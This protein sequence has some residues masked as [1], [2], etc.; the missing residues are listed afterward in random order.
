MPEQNEANAKKPATASVRYFEPRRVRGYRELGPPLAAAAVLLLWVLPASAQNSDPLEVPV[1]FDEDRARGSVVQDFD[2][3]VPY[4]AVAVWSLSGP[5]RG[6]FAIAADGISRAQL[7]FQAPPD[8]EK[9]ADANR[10]N[11]YEVTVTARVE[12]DQEQWNV[13]VTVNNR[14]AA[15]V[16]SGSRSV[17]FAENSEEVVAAYVAT[18]SAGVAWSVAGADGHLFEIADGALSFTAAPDFE[19]RSRPYQLTVQATIGS[20]TGELDVVVIVTDVDEPLVFIHAPGNGMVNFPETSGTGVATYE[21]FDPEGQ[22]VSW[23][24]SGPDRNLFTIFRGSL[25]FKSRLDFETNKLEYR[26]TVTARNGGGAVSETLLV[27][28]VDVDEDGELSLSSTKPQE[29]TELTVTLSDPDGVPAEEETTWRWYRLGFVRETGGTLIQ[30]ADSAVYTPEDA[31][32]GSFLRAE[33]D[34]SHDKH[35]SATELI[36]TERTIA[37]PDSNSRPNAFESEARNRSVRENSAG[38]VGAPVTTTD[39]DGNTLTYSLSRPDTRL[40]SID[41]DSGQIS[42][43]FKFDHE[44]RSSYRVTVTARDPSKSS[45]TVPVNITVIDVDE[46]LY[47]VT[48][49]SEV[50][51]PENGSGQVGSYDSIDIE[52]RPITWSVYGTD[53]SHFNINNRGVLS[54]NT[55]PDYETKPRYTVTVQATSASLH[56]VQL[57]GVTVTVIDVNEPLSVTGETSVTYVENSRDTVAEYTATDPERETPEWS[58]EGT[59]RAFFEIGSDGRLTFKD[60]PDY[61]A[62]NSRYQVT[63]VASDSKF[64]SKLPV[65]V[66]VTNV[67]EDGAVTLSSS[68][69]LVGTVLRAQVLDPDGGVVATSWKW[70]RWDSGDN[71]WSS[72]PGATSATY[73]PTDDDDGTPLR[74]IVEY[75]DAAGSSTVQTVTETVDRPSNNS[76]PEF[77]DSESGK[78]RVL[79]NNRRDE[80]LDYSVTAHDSDRDRLRYSLSGRDSSTFSIDEST[81]EIQVKQRLDHES[82]SSYT[83]KV[84]ATDPQGLT[85]QIDMNIKVVDVDEPGVVTITPAQVVIGRALRATLKDPDAGVAGIFWTWER[86][87]DRTGPWTGIDEGDA[88]RTSS[89]YTPTAADEGHF[90]RATAEYF[91]GVG[92]QDEASQVTIY[93]THTTITATTS[94]NRQSVGNSGSSSGPGPS[95]GPAPGPGPTEPEPEPETVS[96]PEPEPESEEDEAE[97]EDTE[98]IDASEVFEDV[99]DGAYFEQAVAWMVSEG[100]TEGC[101]Q[102]RLFCPDADVTRAQFVTFLWRAAGKPEPSQAGSAVFGDVVEDSFANAAVGWAAETG[103]TTGCNAAADPD[104]ALFCPSDPVT[105][106]QVAALLHRFVGEPASTHVHGFTDVDPGAY[107]WVA[108]AWTAEHGLDDGCDSGTT[109]CPDRPAS[110]AETASFIYRVGTTP[111]SW[112]LGNSSFE[113]SSIP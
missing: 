56:S 40:F 7:R 36:I 49:E 59:D 85:D 87:T 75:R 66:T 57:L 24:L 44:I 68:Q 62:R 108:V 69:P 34:Y 28:L 92:S 79:E 47:V 109:F 1:S 99:E 67:A 89:S 50:D 10:D 9:P 97:P 60:S 15:P 106:A 101:E 45:V 83:F 22:P 95:P 77:P 113:T 30:D 64:S 20:L 39:P 111:E 31:D 98:L 43:R 6:D 2:V 27:T 63:V 37:A 86:S 82:K 33:V 72:I 25:Y 65:T 53:S 107:Y 80:R 4:D 91:D 102:G 19:E 94:P 8:F 26:V 61:E 76:A 17:S 21:V 23:S 90:L 5:D 3:D 14:D 11:V 78:R 41:Q 105:G 112:V 96:E 54:F 18:P 32:F 88:G 42:A 73:K 48:G 38:P 16:V 81:G 55:S 104:G 58:L 70:E 46:G 93:K 51:Y 71:D 100:I 35:G 52:N 29:G 103:V 110:R 74:V 12:D 13:T 84:T